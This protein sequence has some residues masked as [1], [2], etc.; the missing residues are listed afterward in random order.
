MDT[1][2]TEINHVLLDIFNLRI[3]IY[4]LK[5]Q[6]RQYNVGKYNVLN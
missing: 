1:Y 6:V 3:I 5:F 2:F 4:N